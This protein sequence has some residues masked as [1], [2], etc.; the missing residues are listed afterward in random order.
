MKAEAAEDH[1]DLLHSAVPTDASYH[2]KFADVMLYFCCF[3][4]CIHLDSELFDHLIEY[5][6]IESEQNIEQNK[7]YT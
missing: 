1:L 7:E 4:C 5:A 2:Q 6:D 3:N